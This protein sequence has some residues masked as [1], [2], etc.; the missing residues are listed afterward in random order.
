MAGGTTST[1]TF[2]V[3]VGLLDTGSTLTSNGVDGNRRFG[4]VCAITEIVD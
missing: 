2:K 1:T 4:R 3:R